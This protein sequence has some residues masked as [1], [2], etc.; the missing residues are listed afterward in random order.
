[1]KRR[2]FIQAS[3]G[4][5]TASQIPLKAF[6][7]TQQFRK[8]NIL[9]ITVDEMRFPQ[10]FPSGKDLDWYLQ[11]FMPNLYSLW[12]KSVKFYNH[13]SAATYC[14]PARACMMTGLYAHQSLMLAN[15]VI[16]NSTVSIGSSLPTSYPTYG[17]GLRELG[18]DTWYFGKW[19][20]SYYPETNG[21][22]QYGFKGGTTPDPVGGGGDAGI[23]EDPQIVDQFLDW[24]ENERSKINQPWTAVVSLINPHDAFVWWNSQLEDPFQNRQ[25]DKPYSLK[26]IPQFY[27][28]PAENFESI[29]QI[30]RPA[31]HNAIESVNSIAGGAISYNEK[32]QQF[33][34]Q[35]IN[36]PIRNRSLNLPVTEA[37]FSYWLRG[38][39]FYAYLQQ[40]VDQQIGRVL[41]AVANEDV[42]IV[43]TSD[44]G[45]Y[46]GSHG[47]RAKGGS[48][49]RENSHVPLIVC[50]FKGEYTRQPD[51]LRKSLTSHVDF[52]SLLMT[53]GNQGS[54]SW[55]NILPEYKILYQERHNMFNMLVD[56]NANGRSYILHT[57]D[58]P[59]FNDSVKPH[60]IGVRTET[61]TLASYTQW[62]DVLSPDWQTAEY[63]F[64]DY[65]QP[66]GFLEMQNTY[67]SAY[68][69]KVQEMLISK[70]QQELTAP[71]PLSMQADYQR[72]K[73]QYLALANV[74]GNTNVKWWLVRRVRHESHA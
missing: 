39:D 36:I 8:S 4:S 74:I 16:E 6:A 58:E 10:H 25:D 71:L 57:F 34:R 17:K 23:K 44:H 54:A 9:I 52:F 37:P 72:L 7:Q 13:H 5:L 47:M 19:H 69:R 35:I 73:N 18:Y 32:Q 30:G 59:Y 65:N 33:S 56:P 1:M 60:V 27:D 14:T 66:D 29:G 3:V 42:V 45:D 28:L 15:L 31:L 50:D 67:G 40:Q 2:T 41:Q 11:T 70:A 20:L 61:G 22:E 62:N 26:D 68:G 63:Q 24:F 64:F 38:L 21:L 46:V 48:A 43:F 55:L 53:I 12:K 51:I 49:Y